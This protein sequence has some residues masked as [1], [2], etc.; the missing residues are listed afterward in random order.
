[1]IEKTAVGSVAGLS[2]AHGPVNVMDT[3]MLRMITE[4]FIELSGA[5]GPAAVVL[6]GAGRAF[7]AGVDLRSLLDGGPG[8]VAEF[9]PALS[10][11]LLAAFT[12]DRPLVAAVNGHAIAGG[13]V[14]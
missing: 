1:M 7:S 14:L 2:M 4:A 8:Y 10:D 3:A 13:A 9:L 5:D 11:A 12:L 6:T